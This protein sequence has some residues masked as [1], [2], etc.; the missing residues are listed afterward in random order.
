VRSLAI[1]FLV[2][3]CGPL[4][5]CVSTDTSIFVV[6]TIASPT[7]TVKSGALGTGITA[8]SF[9]LDL[10]LGPRADG[11]STVTLGEFNIVDATMTTDI[12]KP[13]NVIGDMMFPVIVLPGSD[14]DTNF[15]L[16]PTAMTTLSGPDA[17]ALCAAA[18]VVIGGA[19]DDSLAGNHDPVY[20]AVFKPS[21]CP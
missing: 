10:H 16:D 14:V 15:T 4:T 6:P 5:G 7:V 8:V 18:G 9:A 12:G 11:E 19:V 20:S 3:A 21:G 13:L 1:L 2:A 17:M